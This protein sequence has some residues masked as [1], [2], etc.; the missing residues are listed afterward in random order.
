MGVI[1]APLTTSRQ[2][3]SKRRQS[4]ASLWKGRTR[5][6]A[7]WG[8]GVDDPGIS[9]RNVARRVGGQTC[10]PGSSRLG[11]PSSRGGLASAV[12]SNEAPTWCLTRA[13]T[14]VRRANGDPAC[15]LR[16]LET[17][18]QRLGRPHVARTLIGLTSAMRQVSGNARSRALGSLCPHGRLAL[19]RTGGCLSDRDCAAPAQGNRGLTFGSLRSSFGSSEPSRSR[20]CRCA[21][22]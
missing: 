7:G 20:A 9:I 10:M 3:V 11:R 13:R 16:F 4:K 5:S 22:P 12:A 8:I 2:N 19:T 6:G 1:P 15:G 14:S 17:G 18:H 21:N